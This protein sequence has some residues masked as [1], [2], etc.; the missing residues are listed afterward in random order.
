MPATK[1]NIALKE[2]LVLLAFLAIILFLPLGI[3][4]F[5][6]QT[7]WTEVAWREGT[8]IAMLEW[9]SAFF[10]VFLFLLLIEHYKT[11]RRAEFAFLA[12]GFLCMGI[13][14]FFYSTIVPGSESAMCLRISTL[15][16]GGAFFSL[17]VL[18]G[19]SDKPADIPGVTV[20]FILPG[21][22]LAGLCI[23]GAI[24]LDQLIPNM[25]TPSGNVS[26]FG[27]LVLILPCLLF[28]FNALFWLHIYIK[29]KNRVDFL[30]AT[31]ILVFAQMTLLMRGASTWGII[32]WLLHIVI[33][34]AVLVAC[35]YMLVLSVYRSIV[36]KLVFS[37]G[38]AFSLT[39]LLASGIMQSASERQFLR[40]FQNS[41]HEQHRRIILEAES[42]FSFAD[43]AMATI[44]K[45]AEGFDAEDESALSEHID[46]FLESKALEW[47]ML[48]IKFGFTRERTP[49][50]HKARSF[51]SKLPEQESMPSRQKHIQEYRTAAET[52]RW[53]PF[54]FEGDSKS[55]MTSYVSSFEKNNVRGSFYVSLDVS[56]IRDPEIVKPKD[57]TR[58]G[59]CIV[60][61]RSNGEIFCD[62]LPDLHVTGAADIPDESAPDRNELLR[63]LVAM[64]IDI[65]KAGRNFIMPVSGNKY[66]VSANSMPSAGWIVIHMIDIQNFPV[67]KR[68]L[69]FLFISVGMITLLVGFVLLLLMLHRQLSKP[70]LKLLS[71]TKQLEKGDFDV[72]VDLSDRT[73]IGAISKAFGHMAWRLKGLYS[74]LASTIHS[75]T[76]ALEKVR[77]ADSA[78]DVF[79]QN[80]SHELRTPMHGILSFARLGLKLDPAGSPEKVTKYFKNIN[81]SAERLMRMID[82]IM[83]LTK[84]ESGRMTFNFQ[85]SNIILPFLQAEDEL[86]AFIDEKQI[87]LVKKIP[88]HDLKAC[89]DTDMVLRVF[90][91]LLGNAV[92]MSNPGSTI[93]AVFDADSESVKFSVF[94]DGPGVPEED[95]KNIFD[96]FVQAGEGKKRGGTGLGLSV[97]REIIAAHGGSIWAANREKGG[98]C[99][100]FKIPFDRKTENN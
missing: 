72:D 76:E 91:N 39:V 88:G 18:G 20:K 50:M 35:V 25:L 36:W 55:W 22:L 60:F 77:L 5:F 19:K 63:Q 30:F 37:L 10:H 14:N 94:D 67:D 80:V 51:R 15:I 75:R 3:L 78:K 43:F 16:L 56:R 28:F 6:G 54:V 49:G 57:L 32:W 70:L 64:T 93:E 9:T 98:A 69:G 59:G 74:D 82:S 33:F 83:D 92:K 7:A 68:G 85:K 40:N 27:R 97:C 17:S 44:L 62:Y 26:L 53:S 12:C 96:K 46:R 41:L 38:L 8:D 1:T 100:S 79:F 24:S 48:P 34:V 66:F 45:D 71:A 52:P 87:S 11:S 13:M 47:A 89:L 21:L 58:Q 86:K 42:G 90:R 61:N 2:S 31:V 84:L 99:F 95:L 4:R 29:E 23:W 81:I 65:D 73:E